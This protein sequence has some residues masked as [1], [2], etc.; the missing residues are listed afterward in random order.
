MLGNFGHPLIII[1]RKDRNTTFHAQFE[2]F[3]RFK[4]K[5]EGLGLG[6]A[7]AKAIIEA[8]GGE[9]QVNSTQGEGTLFQIYLPTD[10]E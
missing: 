10:V 2:R 6:L 4:H 5:S 8:H 9:I 1:A 3:V 7:I